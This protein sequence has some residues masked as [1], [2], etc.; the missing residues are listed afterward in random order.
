[1]AASTFFSN[2]ATTSSRLLVSGGTGTA[3][4]TPAATSASACERTKAKVRWPL[5]ESSPLKRQSVGEKSPVVRNGN[6]A[7]KN[8]VEKLK[9]PS[10][11][12]DEKASAF[13]LECTTLCF[14]RSLFRL[15][16]QQ[17]TGGGPRL[18]FQ[19]TTVSE[20]GITLAQD[21]YDFAF[22]PSRACQKC[23]LGL[24]TCKVQPTEAAPNPNQRLPLFN[25]PQQD[26]T[27]QPTT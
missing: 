19:V 22:S 6:Q 2:V 1:M 23:H 4:A 11:D 16:F 15:S 5:H 25:R 24:R 12:W 3:P 7:R 18:C 9:A 27:I 26:A 20:R 21:C 17:R 13:S 8:S 14:P 10:A